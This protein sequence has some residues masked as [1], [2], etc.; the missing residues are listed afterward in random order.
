MAGFAVTGADPGADAGAGGGVAAL[1]RAGVESAAVGFAGA[2]G[3]AGTAGSGFTCSAGGDPMG[4]CRGYRP[5]GLII[6]EKGIDENAGD[7]H[8][9]KAPKKEPVTPAGFRPGFLN[10]RFFTRRIQAFQ[11]LFITIE[12]RLFVDSDGPGVL[13]DEISRVDR[14]R[15][16]VE[17]PVLHCREID[18]A[19]SCRLKDV[20]QGEPP[21]LAGG[22]Q[23]LI[24]PRTARAPSPL[25]E[26]PFSHPLRQ[27][28]LVS[29]RYD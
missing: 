10:L 9:G 25:P 24:G 14:R 29:C 4:L 17:I 8:D 7:D 26:S 2:T 13:P 21:G 27:N 3:T 11:I 16:R 28:L 22:L 1:P 5:V 23:V 15:K 19:D 6:E 20:P 18:H 12:E